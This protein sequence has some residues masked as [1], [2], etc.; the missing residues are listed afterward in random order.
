MTASPMFMY[1]PKDGSLVPMPL[2]VLDKVELIH[3]IPN[4][5][6]LVYCYELNEKDK[7]YYFKGQFEDQGDENE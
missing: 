2:W 7:N 6:D 1:G 4:G 5:K 3:H